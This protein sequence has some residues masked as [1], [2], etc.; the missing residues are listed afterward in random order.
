ME[1][2]IKELRTEAEQLG[3]KGVESFTTKKQLLVVMDAV[4]SKTPGVAQPTSPEDIKRYVSKA[5][6][7]KARLEAQPLVRFMIP[8]SPGQKLKDKPVHPVTLNGYRTLVRKGIMVDIPEQVAEEL[9]RS[10]N[11]TSVAG[12]EHR[13]D[14]D[15]KVKKALT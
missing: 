8:L 14:R 2:T 10:L 4:K 9:S 15:D 11:M 3:I 7:M 6:A 12:E 13:L 1:K 5:A